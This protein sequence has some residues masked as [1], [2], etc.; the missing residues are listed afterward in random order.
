APLRQ[1][2]KLHKVLLR[3]GVTIKG[4]ANAIGKVQRFIEQLQP[5]HVESAE[6]SIKYAGYIAKEEEAVS[7]MN[8]LENVRLLETFDYSTI[9]G[10]SSEAQEK[11]NQL[12]P[13]SIGQ[14]SRI[15]GVSPADIS[16]LLVH[17]GR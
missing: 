16:I 11:L 12:K 1:K 15:S 14:A 13:S 3:P 4:L 8:R 6:V 10:L 5:D 7:K 2:M 17:A 9:K